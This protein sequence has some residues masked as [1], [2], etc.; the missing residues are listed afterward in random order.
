M[1]NRDDVQRIVENVLR[2]LT[3]EIKNGDFTDP[4]SRTIFLKYNGQEIDR[5]SFNVVQEREYEG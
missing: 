3:L 5:V 2:D 4:N 1:L